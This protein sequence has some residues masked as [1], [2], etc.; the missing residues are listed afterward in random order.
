MKSAKESMTAALKEF[1]ATDEQANKLTAGYRNKVVAAN[2]M[3]C[4]N[5]GGAMK[6]VSLEGGVP[7]RYCAVDRVTLPMAAK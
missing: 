3:T 6:R 5:C 1:G 4:P 7:A 2:S